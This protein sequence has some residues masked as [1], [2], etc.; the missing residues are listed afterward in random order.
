[1]E[2]PVSSVIIPPNLHR[3]GTA[4]LHNSQS[5]LGERNISEFAIEKEIGRGAYG[6]VK[7]ARE[8]QAQGTLGVRYIIFRVIIASVALNTGVASIGH[9][10]NHQVAHTC[11]LLEKTPKFRYYPD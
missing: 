3:V 7:L 6:L 10:T 5:F 9:Q 4:P 2:P 1:M 8:I 11:R